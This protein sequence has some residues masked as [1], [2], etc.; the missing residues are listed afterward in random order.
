MEWARTEL[1][2]SESTLAVI[3]QKDFTGPG[4]LKVDSLGELITSH[5]L[6][7]GAAVVLCHHAIGKIIDH[8]CTAC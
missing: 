2:L 5:G 3:A 6:P 4:L 7:S 8:L 1:K